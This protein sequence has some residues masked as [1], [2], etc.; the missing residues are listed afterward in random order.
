MTALAELQT[1][2]KAG[3]QLLAERMHD[4]A[5]TSARRTRRTRRRTG[6]QVDP[7][8]SQADSLT[9]SRR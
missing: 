1:D 5:D 7:A 4:L 6:R 8:S 3:A 9:R 2:S